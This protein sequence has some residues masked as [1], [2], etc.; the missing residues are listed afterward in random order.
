MVYVL[1][2][3]LLPRFLIFISQF[4][5][6]HSWSAL[7]LPNSHHES[8]TSNRK[9]CIYCPVIPGLCACFHKHSIKWTP[10]CLPD[11]T[12]FLN[13]KVAQGEITTHSVEFFYLNRD[14]WYTS[15]SLVHIC[16]ICLS[17]S[18]RNK[19]TKDNHLGIRISTN[20]RHVE[21]GRELRDRLVQPSPVL[22]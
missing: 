11:S 19:W 7:I 1:L 20:I 15:I 22:R 8:D 9:W 12:I 6:L 21:Q 17:T 18:F 5:S 3:E 14:C 4:L 2:S 13:G 10:H 16:F